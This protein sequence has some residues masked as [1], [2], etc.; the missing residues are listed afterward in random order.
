MIIRVLSLDIATTTGWA[1]MFGAASRRFEYGLIKTSPKFSLAE[2][3]CFFRHEIKKLLKELRPTHVVMEDI[4]S[5]PNNKTLVTLAKFAGVCEECCLT[6]SGIQ[7]YLMHTSTVK[8]YFKSKNKEDIFNFIVDILEWDDSN[9][10][11]NKHNDLTDAIAQLIV[12]YDKVLEY[13]KFRTEKEYGYLY[14]V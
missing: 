5:G 14:E 13:R 12:F 9:V 3:L 11:F 6:V 4:Y 2:R 1:F 8:S 10:N 7:P